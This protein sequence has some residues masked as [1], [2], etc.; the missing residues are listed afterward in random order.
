MVAG[1][2][3]RVFNGPKVEDARV[4]SIRPSNKPIVL[5]QALEYTRG[6]LAGRAPLARLEC[7]LIVAGAFGLFRKD[8]VIDVGGYHTGTV[9]EDMEISARLHRRTYEQGSHGRVIFV[10]DPVC[11]TQVPSDWRSPAAP[12][13]PVAARPPGEPLDGGA[14]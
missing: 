7:L 1:G 12:A 10:P 13:R 3:I 9:C 11:W 8:A 5:W 4:T 14:A 6:L 2:I